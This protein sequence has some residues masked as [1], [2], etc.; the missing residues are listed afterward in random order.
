MEDRTL[1]ARAAP[2]RNAKR[3]RLKKTARKIETA[4]RASS[5][6]RDLAL[7]LWTDGRVHLGHLGHK[8][9]KKDRAVDRA[10]RIHSVAL[11]RRDP[12]G[13]SHGSASNAATGAARFS[14]ARLLL[15]RAALD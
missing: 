9:S 11:T 7:D 3:K 6:R 10:R 12:S 4:Q 8:R 15:G 2:A 13:R 5:K 14:R 1:P